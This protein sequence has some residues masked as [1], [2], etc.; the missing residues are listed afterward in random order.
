MMGTESRSPLV[1]L[2]NSLRFWGI[3][4]CREA[5]ILMHV[6]TIIFQ[7][8]SSAICRGVYFWQGG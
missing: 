3:L 8:A 4:G 5:H 2:L 6:I 1:D 7:K